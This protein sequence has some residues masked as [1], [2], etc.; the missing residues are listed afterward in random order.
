MNIIGID[1]ATKKLGF[2]VL[3]YEDSKAKVLECKTLVVTGDDCFQRMYDIMLLL[4]QEL[5]KYIVSDEDVVGIEMQNI[6]AN[7]WASSLN[8]Q[9]VGYIRCIIHSINSN[10]KIVNVEN[11]MWKKY[12]TGQKGAKKELAKE[13]ICEKYNI[14]LENEYLDASDA[15]CIADTTLKIIGDRHNENRKNPLSK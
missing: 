2:S 6:G 14:N 1:P 8:N 13:I 11:G 4:R 5:E 7:R 9:V 15:L 12:V 10:V 3:S